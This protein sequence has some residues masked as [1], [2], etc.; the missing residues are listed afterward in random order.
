MQQRSAH[1]A[2][3]LTLLVLLNPI[4]IKGMLGIWIDRVIIALVLIVNGYVFFYEE[5]IALRVGAPTTLE[6]ILGFIAYIPC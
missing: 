6:I 5:S 2:F 1:V 4:K 3:A